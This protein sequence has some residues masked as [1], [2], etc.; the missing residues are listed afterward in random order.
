MSS[1]EIGMDYQTAVRVSAGFGGGM[2]RMGEVCGAATGAFMARDK[3][4][5]FTVCARIVRDAAEILQEFLEGQCLE[6]Q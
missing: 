1:S 2:G 3:N 6:E 5:H 4:L